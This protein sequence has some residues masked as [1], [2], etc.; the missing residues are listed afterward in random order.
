MSKQKSLITASTMRIVLSALLLL[1][2]AGMI[3][4][5]SFAY[6]FLDS[7]ADET[8]RLQ[9]EATASGT[10]VQNLLS[11]NQQLSQHQSAVKK[12]SQIVAE[13]KS[14]QYQNQI[15]TDLSTYAVRAGVAIQS[16]SFNDKANSSSNAS[17]TDTPSDGNTDSSTG[18]KSTV[19]SIQLA[20]RVPY[21]NLL[22]FLHLL[23]QN[24]TRMQTAGVSL[25]STENNGNVTVQALELEVYIR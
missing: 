25:V 22:H 8:A 15:I 5:F 3:G 2:L 20:E 12:A 1:V 6:S 18:P 14:Y 4:G 21:P 9:A 11:L 10:K 7:A 19:V 24:I 16:F 23:E 17:N 13:S